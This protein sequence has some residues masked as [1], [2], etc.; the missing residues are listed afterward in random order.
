MV[1]A[2]QQLTITLQGNMPTR[3]E[4]TEALQKVSKLFTKIAMV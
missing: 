4:T 2:A 1:V 3:N